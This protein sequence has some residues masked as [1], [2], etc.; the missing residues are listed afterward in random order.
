MHLESYNC[1]LCQL[2]S[3]ETVEH[4]FL[5]CQFAK[6]CWA[7][8]GITIQADQDIILAVE[9]VRA[10]SHPNLFLMV[11][12]LMSWAIWNARNDFIFKNK[13]P[14]TIAVKALFE[15]EMRIHSLRA[16]SRLSHTFDLW[17]QNLL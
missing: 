16:R 6:E 8:I 5:G 2:A 3:E 17:I 4:L 12:I 9:Q 11:T 15:K 13:Q 10:Q 1:V 7:L 14:S